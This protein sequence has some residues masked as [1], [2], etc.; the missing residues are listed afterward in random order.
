MQAGQKILAC[1]PSNTGVDN[2][3]EKLAR[4]RLRVVRVGHPAR[5]Q[6]E[7]QGY[8]LDAL[9]ESDPAMKIVAEMHR[10]ADK[11]MKKAAKFTRAKPAPG[12]R[13][14]LRQEARQLRE[15]A[16]LYEKQIVSNI[17]ERADVICA[18]TNFDPEILGDRHF[19]TVVV[20]EA[21]QSTEPGCWPTILKANR[22]IL[23]GDHCQLPPTILSSEAAKQG[24]SISLMEACDSARNEAQSATY[25]SVP[26][27]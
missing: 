16:K 26:N 7:L 25:R 20:D 18:T 22:L 5:V 1:A 21:C 24:F 10:E 23:A 2:L 3:L 4:N 14:D 15:D 19:D 8:T 17:L 6:Q 11:I 13:G 27:A 9:A 12:A